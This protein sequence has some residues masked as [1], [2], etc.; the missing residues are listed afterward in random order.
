MNL[1]LINLPTEKQPADRD[2]QVVQWKEVEVDAA[3]DEA[4]E[5]VAVVHCMHFRSV[6]SLDL[7]LFGFFLLEVLLLLLNHWL[8]VFEFFICSVRIMSLWGLEG[9]HFLIVHDLFDFNL[10]SKHLVDVFVNDEGITN[11][12][13]HWEVVPLSEVVVLNLDHYFKG[14][15]LWDNVT[16]FLLGQ[17]WDSICYLAV[18]VG[19][20]DQGAHDKDCKGIS[21]LLAMEHHELR[22]R[23]TISDN[24]TAGKVKKADA[25]ELTNLDREVIVELGLLLAWAQNGRTENKLN[26]KQEKHLEVVGDLVFLVDL[27][28]LFVL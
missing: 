6:P 11:R 27:E 8:I 15:K 19:Q 5:L 3:E 20:H 16:D 12:T 24:G 21:E 23:K 9:L 7:F 18:D 1:F 2:T 13:S 25:E 4:K 22:H 14:N 10:L 28:L 17:C 26:R